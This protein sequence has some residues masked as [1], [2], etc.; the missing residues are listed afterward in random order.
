MFRFLGCPMRAPCAHVSKRTTGAPRNE[1][2]LPCGLRA[3]RIKK[4]VLVLVLG[5]GVCLLFGN[6]AVSAAN[7]DQGF[8]Q[9]PASAR[10]WVYWFWL[11]G[12]ITRAGITADLEA[13]QRAGIGGVLIMEVDQGAP[14]GPADFAGRPWRALFQHVCAEADRLGLQVNMNNDAGWCGSG[15][16]WITP[17]LAM[18]KLVWTETTVQGP[19]AFTGRLAQPT[20]V[21]DY[22]RDITVLA[23]PTP[24][25]P[26][27]ITGVRGKAM[28]QPISISLAIPGT[29]PKVASH[30]VVD[31]GKIVDLTGRLQNDGMLTWKVPDGRWTILRIGHTPTG[32]D[33]HP[34]PEA[35][36]GLECD[37]LSK[38]GSEAAF[39]GLMGKL[40][41]DVGPLAGKTLVSTHIDSWEVGSQNWTA[42]FRREFQRRRGY[43]PLPLLPIVTGYVLDSAET[44]ERFLWDMRQTISELLLENYAGH[45]RELAHRH[46]MRLSIEAYTNCPCNEL[47]YAGR[48]DEPMGEFWSWTKFGAAFSCTEMASAAHVYGKPIVGAEAFTATNTEK[49]LG[50]PGN[51]KDLGDWAFCEGINRFVFHRYALQPWR[52]RRP[53]MSMGP[54]GLHYERTQTWW[55]QS[56]AW[57]A[58]L[59]RCQYLL[60]QGRFVADICFLG[61]EGAPQTINGQQAFR[62]KSGQPLERPPYN[63]DVCPPEVVLTRMSVKD[64]R[65]VLPDGMSYRLLVLPRVDR[66]TP[67]LLAKIEQLVKAG[68]TIVGTPP[69]KSP[70][71]S[72][73][74]DGDAQLHQIARRLWG[75]GTAPPTPMKRHI[76]RGQ[77]VWGGAFVGREQGGPTSSGLETAQW[78]WYPEGQPASSA[79]VGTRYFRRV[80][81]IPKD[82]TI[83]S[84]RFILTADN[85]FECWVNGQ[86]AGGGNTY[87]HTYS[88]DIKSLLRP[89]KNV[90]AVAA[91]NG[92]TAP[93]PAGMIGAVTVRFRSGTPVI[94]PTDSSWQAAA[95]VP[96]SWTSQLEPTT[97]WHAARELGPIGMAPWG[98]IDQAL[99]RSDI[100][101]AVDAVC[102]VL[103]R[104][105]VPA[106][107]RYNSVPTADGLRYI[108]RVIDG[109]QIYF[110]ANKTADYLHA[111]CHFRVSDKCP[112]LWWP[113]SG[114]IERAAV[115]SS[116]GSVT[117][118]PL[119]LGPTESVFV[120]FRQARARGTD[121]VTR[122]D[123]N[124]QEVLGSIDRA[125]ASATTTKS[126]AP[127]ITLVLDGTGTVRSTVSRPGQYTVHFASGSV[128]KVSVA[129]LP[130]PLQVT[131]PWQVEFMP[132]WGGP[133]RIV[134]P[135]LISWSQHA[136]A[137]VKYY[138]GTA[139]YRQTVQLP[140]ELLNP[141]RRLVLDLGRVEVMAQVRLNGKDLGILWKSP[142]QVDI[143]YA[144]RPGENRLEIA[145]T[146]LW[147]NRMIGDAQLPEDSDRNANGTLKSW[148]RWLQ[149]DQTSPT[150]RL[151]FTSWRLWT[152]DAP[153]L[154]SGLL[155]PVRVMTQVRVR[156]SPNA[157]REATTDR[158][159]RHE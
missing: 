53:G 22:Y 100:F 27:R 145:V 129:E 126:D 69:L 33:N 21:A 35:G 107:F 138:S 5:M 12:N 28:F 116:A 83:A 120:V 63:F 118:L 32:K 117:S 15:G 137:G 61:P 158:A 68:A 134:L 123:Y 42:D 125:K 29:W 59:A 31:R 148:P 151:T 1:G 97:A 96:D 101:P 74:P 86:R 113:E 79:P 23:F 104:M 81:Q 102:D 70:S 55:E 90:I 20:T 139:T 154:D 9:P 56:R 19:R 14:Q 24:E 26:A 66:M 109:T 105:N 25:K 132:K 122:V 130:A 71:L 150:G 121:H 77:V 37:K 159:S 62:S 84:A 128:R 95:K 82:K 13:M 80:L 146:N 114:R 76:G 94:M 48:A 143:T 58:Y 43:D 54:W 131:G 87:V 36:R 39:N 17:A 141:A 45:F 103:A 140:T 57:H 99:S 65:L 40:I 157:K 44:S 46:G 6:R 10:P 91:T 72:D 108:H 98:D 135:K 67:K 47:A 4:L 89:G 147:P 112:E 152:K 127:P 110:V 73:F 106:D 93:N 136:N 115:F 30:A 38:A 119:D 50:Y 18:Q 11:N 78:I 111:T 2:V 144:A 153:L 34:A 60:Q 133:A 52:D 75:T 149:D 124:G 7:L 156:V 88:L 3:S 155:G 49:W 64:G 8:R 85:S 92:A 41:H 51:I 142:Y 16:P